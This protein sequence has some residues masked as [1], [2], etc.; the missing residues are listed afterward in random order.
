MSE[1]NSRTTTSY[2][3]GE[4]FGIVGAN[5]IVIL[6][7][8]EKSRVAS[9][10][11]I[12]DDGAGFDETLDALIAS[13]LREL[14]GF[15]LVSEQDG[16]TKVVL[17]GDVRARFTASGEQ[18]NLE[19]LSAT[20]W[21]ERALRGVTQMVV[22]VSEDDGDCDLTIEQGLVRISR[23]DRP[24]RAADDESADEPVD[25]PQ[26]EPAD[27][28]T[29]ALPVTEPHPGPEPDVEDAPLEPAFAT[30]VLSTGESVEVSS[31]VLV[32]RAPEARR[33]SSPDP[34]LVQV[35]SPQLMVSATHLE[36]Q[37]GPTDDGTCLVTD[38]GSTNG[39]VLTLPGQTA[40]GLE[41]G[42]AVTVGPGGLLDL[43]D[44]IIIEVGG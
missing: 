16:E 18:H 17:R 30:L 22:Q 21:V 35:H 29:E 43:G 39:T 13:G 15:L 1:E 27:Q 33:A 37:P 4:W 7:P 8:S 40:I 24:A 11:E 12:L 10:W 20:T 25:E 28:A 38:I 6:P 41:P 3:H 44:G 2:R 42:V 26:D 32:G 31:A 14:P 5:A 9:L 23:L 19:G 36:I 34:R